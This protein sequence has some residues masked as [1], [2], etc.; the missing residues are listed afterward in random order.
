[1]RSGFV[2]LTCLLGLGGA[3]EKDLREALP[4]IPPKEPAEAVRTFRTRDGFRME[5]LAA[6]PLVTDP[7]ALEYDENGRA[8]VVEML[9]YPYTD[10]STDKPFVERTGDLP[11]GRIRV[12]EDTGGDGKFDKSWVFADNL[13]WPTGLAFYQ[14]GVYVTATPD[15]W[16]L[17]DTDGDGKADVREKVFTGFRKFNVQAVINNLRWGL[18][19]KI[20]GAGA[21]NGGKIVRPGD[22][23]A[24]PVVM[25]ARDFRFDPA[26]RDFELLSGGA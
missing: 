11:L 3:Q 17:K 2:L 14:G 15:V 22:P 9:D 26:A 20:Y 13:S 5:L 6:E 19:H 4:R 1:M 23:K 8:W 24:S 7:V 21:T 18:D 12:L 16:Y 10:K 25:G